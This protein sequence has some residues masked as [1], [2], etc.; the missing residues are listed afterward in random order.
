MAVGGLLAELESAQAENA[1]GLRR[2]DAMF[3]DHAKVSPESVRAMKEYGLF[4]SRTV[5][6]F[7]RLKL[8]GP[9]SE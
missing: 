7:V 3:P 2:I 9:N 4:L 6:K 1:G 8:I 5:V